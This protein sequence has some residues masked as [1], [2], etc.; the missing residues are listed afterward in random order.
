V[1]DLMAKYWPG[2][3]KE[4][5][6]PKDLQEDINNRKTSFINSILKQKITRS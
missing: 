1:Y 4:I 3:F 5:G 6:S 2:H